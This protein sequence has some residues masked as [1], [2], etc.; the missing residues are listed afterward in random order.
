MRVFTLLVSPLIVILS[1]TIS[2]VFN[3]VPTPV[4]VALSAVTETVPFMCAEGVENTDL[5]CRVAAA[6]AFTAAE[7]DALVECATATVLEVTVVTI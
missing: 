5:F 1:P 6:P 2:C 7:S 3:K 4:T